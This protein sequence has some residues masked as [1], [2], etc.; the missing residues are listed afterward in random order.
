MFVINFSI[1]KGLWGSDPWCGWELWREESITSSELAV[2]SMSNDMAALAWLGYKHLLPSV[3]TRLLREP[4]LK[5][6]QKHN[7]KLRST[8]RMLPYIWILDYCKINH[9]LSYMMQCSLY[10]MSHL[11]CI[12]FSITRQADEDLWLLS[13]YL[14][15][16]PMETVLERSTLLINASLSCKLNTIVK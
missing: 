8:R 14:H 11:K 4:G 10:F 6:T 7:K 12:T 13:S 3:H 2:K 5:T 9:R 15:T 1:E 16:D